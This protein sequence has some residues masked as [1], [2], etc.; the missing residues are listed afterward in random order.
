M[1]VYDV[2]N[3]GPLKMIEARLCDVKLYDYCEA[4]CFID[5]ERKQW[6]CAMKR[7]SVYV[8][9]NAKCFPFFRDHSLN[10]KK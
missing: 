9:A 2:E 5:M 8:D 3:E 4:E 10:S 1:F 7:A 6:V